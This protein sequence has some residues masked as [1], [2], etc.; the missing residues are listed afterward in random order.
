MSPDQAVN[1]LFASPLIPFAF[2]G[3]IFYFLIWKPENQKKNQHKDMLKNLKKNDEI[4][5][6]SGIHGTIVNVKDSTI[7]VRVDDN[8]KLELDKEA[9]GIV[10]S[11]NKQ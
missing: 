1:P 10:K 7:I 8:V 6:A 4:I 11:Q 5:T 3:V 9:V 2:I